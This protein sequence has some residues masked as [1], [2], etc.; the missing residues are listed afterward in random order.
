MQLLLA[1]NCLQKQTLENIQSQFEKEKGIN[2]EQ[3]HELKKVDFGC[4]QMND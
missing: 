2:S 1:V 4:I 3:R